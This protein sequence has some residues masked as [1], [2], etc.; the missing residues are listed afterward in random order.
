[1][2]VADGR[3]A[4][5]LHGKV[6]LAHDM[7]SP[8]TA[9]IGAAIVLVAKQAAH[10][11]E[12]L[13]RVEIRRIFDAKVATVQENSGLQISEG[14][15]ECGRRVDDD[16]A[17]RGERRAVGVCVNDAGQLLRGRWRWRGAGC[18]LLCIGWPALARN[19]GWVRLAARVC[20]VLSICAGVAGSVAVPLVGRNAGRKV[21]RCAVATSGIHVRVGW[22]RIWPRRMAVVRAAAVV[23][24]FV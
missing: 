5:A 13:G 14:D 3:G 15:L 2:A 24:V 19:K 9:S 17:R 12:T 22:I 23:C 16:C 10:G 4:L 21:R 20:L 18:G 6:V 7:T 1:M 8:E 11:L